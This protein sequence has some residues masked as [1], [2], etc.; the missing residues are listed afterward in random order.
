[1]WRG[2]KGVQEAWEKGIWAFAASSFPSEV[3]LR[4]C[5]TALCSGLVGFQWPPSCDP[6][7]SPPT[8][9]LSPVVSRARSHTVPPPGSPPNC[10]S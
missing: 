1:M 10:S 2:V 9:S 3:W 7:K 4:C 8:P 5:L 6:G